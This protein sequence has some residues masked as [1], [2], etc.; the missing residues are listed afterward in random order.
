MLYSFGCFGTYYLENASKKVKTVVV[1]MQF[2][3]FTGCYFLS[4]LWDLLHLK[5]TYIICKFLAVIKKKLL[6]LLGSCD[7]PWCRN[8]RRNQLYKA[9]YCG[10]CNVDAIYKNKWGVFS[11]IIS[12]F[13]HHAMHTHTHSLMLKRLSDRER[14]SALRRA[15]HFNKHSCKALV[16]K[17]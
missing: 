7:F 12:I 5:H 4:C 16:A 11:I 1:L 14:G 9:E 2:P 13:S 6:L 15:H 3:S 17:M 8:H 10:I